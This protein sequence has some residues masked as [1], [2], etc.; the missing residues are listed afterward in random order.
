[1]LK[2]TIK[3]IISYFLADDYQFARRGANCSISNG[4]IINSPKMIELGNNVSIGPRA[5]L[6]AV[7]KRIIIG[8]NV[9]FGP[10]VTL[11]NGDHNIHK[12]GVPL[13]DNREKMPEDDAEII[14]GDESWLGA[15]VTVLKGVNIGRGCVVAAGAVVTKDTPP[16]TIVGGV[17][18]KVLKNR[19]SLSEAVK[20]ESI[21][22]PEENRLSVGQLSHLH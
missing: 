10:N 1:M 22:Y 3:K 5:V 16:Y 20:H 19:F 21:L 18:A 4:C 14:I 6:Y 9:L 17:P 8:D 12:I 15:N 2:K 13:K 7:Y 11:V